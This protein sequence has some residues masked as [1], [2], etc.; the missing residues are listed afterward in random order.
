MFSFHARSL[1]ETA[2]LKTS[3][4]C[5]EGAFTVLKDTKYQQDTNKDILIFLNSR[6]WGLEM[7]T[8]YNSNWNIE[9]LPA[10][11]LSAKL[12]GSESAPS[13]MFP[14]QIVAQPSSLLSLLAAA[15]GLHPKAPPPAL[16]PKGWPG[17]EA[18]D[19]QAAVTEALL[20]DTSAE[21]FACWLGVTSDPSLHLEM[22]LQAVLQGCWSCG[23]VNT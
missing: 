14:E 2:Q 11:L 12:Q 7:L 22:P 18:V 6:N 20:W 19:S 3:G 16:V 5:R 10:V 13:V 9:N 15:L 21:V 4:G 1:Q 8:L 17:M 23:C